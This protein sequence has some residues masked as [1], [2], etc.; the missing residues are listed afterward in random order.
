[1]YNV[2]IINTS[3]TIIPAYTTYM[4]TLPRRL[5]VEVTTRGRIYVLLKRKYVS[6]REVGTNISTIIIH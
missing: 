3:S 6:Q 4:K 5:N 1:M 2:A